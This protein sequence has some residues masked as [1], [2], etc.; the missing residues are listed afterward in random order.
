M[1]AEFRRVKKAGFFPISEQK[2]IGK[3]RLDIVKKIEGDFHK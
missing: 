3:Y 1:E 2:N